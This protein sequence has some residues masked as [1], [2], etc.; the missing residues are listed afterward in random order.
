MKPLD[1]PN[2]QQIAKE[3]V[4]LLETVGLKPQAPIIILA[5]LREIQQRIEEGYTSKEII[6]T[7]ELP[8]PP[9]NFGATW[10]KAT[11]VKLADVPRQRRGRT[12]LL[13]KGYTEDQ[14]KEIMEATK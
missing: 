2:V 5:N 11:Q 4:E 6:T 9:T 7:L 8:F 14:V 3:T 10:Y 1:I 13:A 12:N